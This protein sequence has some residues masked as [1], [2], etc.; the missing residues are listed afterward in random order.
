MRLR[1]QKSFRPLLFS[2]QLVATHREINE[3]LVSQAQ[4]GRT[5]ILSQVGLLPLK[6]GQ[7]RAD[8]EGPVA[9]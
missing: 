6:G 2:E 3:L 8:L 1:D 5:Q 4:A 7:L 9:T